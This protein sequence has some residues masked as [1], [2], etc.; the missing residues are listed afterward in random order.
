MNNTQ[1]WVV[2]LGA[3]LLAAVVGAMAYNAGIARGIEQSGKIVVAPAGAT[4]PYYPYYGWYR[5]WGF[6][7]FGPICFIFFWFLILRGLFWRGGWHRR[8]YC[9]G[10][11][12][13]WHRREHEQMRNEGRTDK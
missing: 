11:P 3:L 9:G 12:S 2:I 6:G 7:F 5:P 8:A 1:R 4:A 10:D 13:E